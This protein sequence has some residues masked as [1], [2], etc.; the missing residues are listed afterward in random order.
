MSTCKKLLT[1]LSS[2]LD[3]ELD[4]DLRV[5]I[6]T[7]MRRCPDCHIIIDS[8]RKTVQIYRG[9][10]AYEVPTSL[11]ERIEQAVKMHIEKSTGKC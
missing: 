9:C 7:H 3:N 6:E 8:T 11:H 1:E 10:D 5:E 4:S 2:Y